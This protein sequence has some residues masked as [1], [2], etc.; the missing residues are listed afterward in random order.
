MNSNSQA[1]KTRKPMTETSRAYRQELAARAFTDAPGPSTDAPGTTEAASDTIE[2]ALRRYI[3][4]GGGSGKL[5]DP[6]T[7]EEMG[8]V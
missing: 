1:N 4:A 3:E 5:S 2:S 8:L 7:D 6:Y